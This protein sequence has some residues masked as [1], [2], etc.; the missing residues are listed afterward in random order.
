MSRRFL[1]ILCLSIAIATP[2]MAAGA[3][4][5]PLIAEDKLAK[6]ESDIMAMD[7]TELRAFVGVLVDCHIVNFLVDAQARI[8]CFSSRTK[9]EIEYRRDRA[10]DSVLDLLHLAAVSDLKQG[11]TVSM[12]LKGNPASPPDKQGITLDD[13]RRVT[14]AASAGTP[15][16]NA[17]LI[18]A[19]EMR[20]RKMASQSFQNKRP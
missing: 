19:I 10:V 9:Y 2:A 3:Q 18:L 8:V 11:L 12:N 1:K 4:Q 20:L 7:Q 16:S 13:I 17:G 15:L 6:A 5:E 14:A